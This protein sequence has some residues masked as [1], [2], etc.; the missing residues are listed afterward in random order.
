VRFSAGAA[1]KT[2]LI[3][4]SISCDPR[5]PLTNYAIL[6]PVVASDRISRNKTRD[7][8]RNFDY[9]D[10]LLIWAGC[11]RTDGVKSWLTSPIGER[12]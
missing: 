12:S 10:R 3:E 8:F 6:S 1:V 5:E 7:S 9:L 2:A 11:I 4:S